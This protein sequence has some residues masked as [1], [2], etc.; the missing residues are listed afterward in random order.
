LVFAGGCVGTPA[1]I[2]GGYNITR[3]SATAKKRP[4]SVRLDINHLDQTA[5][6][7][8]ARQLTSE[9]GTAYE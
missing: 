3:D 1:A 4:D 6:L 9:G 8:A 7:E 5:P 2:A